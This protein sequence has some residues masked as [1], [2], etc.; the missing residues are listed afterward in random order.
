MSRS[1]NY[2][3]SSDTWIF[4]SYFGRFMALFKSSKWL[5]FCILVSVTCV[6]VSFSLMPHIYLQREK[7]HINYNT[8][9]KENNFKMIIYLKI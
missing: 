3:P 2:F 9:L 7:D 1:G 6:L 5:K 4:K 8:F